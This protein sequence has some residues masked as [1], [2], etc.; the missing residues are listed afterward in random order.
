M[1]SIENKVAIVTGGS[2]G[3]G[4][5]ISEGFLTA[6]AKVI[7]CARNLPEAEINSA[8]NMADFVRCDVRN[9]DE[10]RNVVDYCESKYGRLDILVNNAGGAPPAVSATA[11][12]KFTR[13][14]VDLNLIAPI[15]FSQTAGKLMRSSSD[16][17]VIINIS[18]I[19][20]MRPNPY[21]VAYGA[22]KAGIINATETLALE[23]GPQIRVVSISA[24]LVLTEESRSFYGDDESVERIASTIPLGRLGKPQDIA[25]ACLFVASDKAAWISGSNIVL[26][27]G[28]ERPSYLD[29]TDQLGSSEP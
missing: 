20:G 12:E 3:I 14:I 15:V 22:S 28:G 19:S 1:K 24:G 18:S 13:S 11:G 29:A 17:S 5:V 2:R 25:D 27:G 10:I 26:H 23:W 4:R 6:G 16:S 9:T 7:V 8:G 21:G